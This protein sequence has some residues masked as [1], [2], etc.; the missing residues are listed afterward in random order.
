MENKQLKNGGL[1]TLRVPKTGEVCHVFDPGAH[2]GRVEAKDDNIIETRH[3]NIESKHQLKANCA[4]IRPVLLSIFV[5]E[6]RVKLRE[7]VE[8]VSMEP[9]VLFFGKFFLFSYG[10]DAHFRQKKTRFFFPFV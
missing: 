9:S 8:K 1:N 2:T 4:I 6:A 5:R 3:L 7:R 10:L